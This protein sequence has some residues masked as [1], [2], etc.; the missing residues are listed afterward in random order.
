VIGD[1]QSRELFH[2]AA[3]AVANMTRE[4]DLDIADRKRAEEALRES[5][6]LFRGAFEYTNVAMV[7]T[8]V[9][10]RFVRVNAAFARLFGYS[11][12]DLLGM[13]MADVTHPDDLAESYANRQAL[14]AGRSHYFQ[15][16]KRYLH[17]D[18]QVFW[19][20]ANISLV[21]DARGQPLQYVG[22]VLDITERKEAETRYRARVEESLRQSEERFHLLVDSVED[23]AILML[24]PDG[25][26]ATWNAGARRLKGYSAEEIVGSHFSRFYPAE[27]L[28]A[29]RP[30]R[31]LQIAREQGRV[32]DEGWRIRKDGSRFWANVVMTALRER[33]G[34][35][36]GF[37]KVTRDFTERKSSE[38][39]VNHLNA[40]LAARI[41]ELDAANRELESFCYSISHDLRAPLRA[42]D[43]FSRILLKDY[44]AGLPE[45]VTG[46]LQDVRANA[47]Q[48]G[49][50]IDDLLAFSRLSRQPL[51]KQPVSP[52]RIVNECLVELQG[53]RQGRKVEIRVGELAE[54]QA[55]PALLKQVW[56]NLL[57]NALKYTGK[58]EA[59]VIEVSSRSV[60]RE[61][62]T[63][64]F[65]KDNGVGF[66]M[67][68]AGKL[69]G[70]FQRLHRAED[71]AGTGVGLAIVQR[72]I[73]RHGG[74]IWADAR[75]DSG[76]AFYFT[77]DG[78]APDE[79]EPR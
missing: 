50:L 32:E 15:M 58:R 3:E 45:D 51:T 10:N 28:A 72:I 78:E 64:Y 36:R 53:E 71:Y 54:C 34:H 69:F 29:A 42:I 49:H 56:I 40:E 6:E 67:K 22:Q 1:F 48:M 77:L 21:R 38:D 4:V 62:A 14:L 46:Y 75:P 24:D 23:Y 20:L 7:V 44:T 47:L 16:E 60:G 66:D 37:A 18:G 5:D 17:K 73:H 65:V 2:S 19:G 59:A 76:A 11:E 31:V 13:T 55:D 35:L 61:P 52:A 9:G 74:R 41:A 57:S 27:D 79:R 33:S 70:V 25:R 12:A 68:Y 30:E 26:I 39:R 8:D 63:T 43:G